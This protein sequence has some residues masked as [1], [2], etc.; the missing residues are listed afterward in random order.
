[1][2][3]PAIETEGE[4]PS[5]SRRKVGGEE[6]PG[7][8]PIHYQ[9]RYTD[10]YIYSAVGRASVLGRASSSCIDTSLGTTDISQGWQRWEALV[11]CLEPVLHRKLPRH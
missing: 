9:C 8:A 7:L 2:Q 3:G 10:T 5:F 11:E 4:K 6:K 1:M